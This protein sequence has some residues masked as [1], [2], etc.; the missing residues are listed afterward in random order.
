MG[1]MID[2]PSASLYI[3]SLFGYPCFI[4]L[5]APWRSLFIL[6]A[7][8]FNRPGPICSRHAPGPDLRPVRDRKRGSSRP[9]RGASMQRRQRQRVSDQLRGVFGGR[10]G[11]WGGVG[12]VEL[13]S[14]VGSIIPEL[15]TGSRGKGSQK[16]ILLQLSWPGGKLAGGEGGNFVFSFAYLIILTQFS[17]PGPEPE[18]EPEPEPKK[19]QRVEKEKTKSRTNLYLYLRWSW[20]VD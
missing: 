15:G 13:G 12:Q 3:I 20:I 8:L 10:G 4:A 16:R 9:G 5:V 19:K 18:P 14:S 2:E 7:R 11:I 17:K 1:G 6:I